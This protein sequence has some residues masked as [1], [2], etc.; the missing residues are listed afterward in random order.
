MDL[1]ATSSVRTDLAAGSGRRPAAGPWRRLWDRRPGRPPPRRAGRTRSPAASARAS[2]SDG[3]R[4]GLDDHDRQAARPRHG[5]VEPVA[6][7]EELDAAR[8]LRRARRWPSSRST[9]APPGPGTCRPC[10]PGAAAEPALERLLDLGDVGVVRRHDEDV[11][12]RQRRTRRPSRSVHG[13]PR[14]G[15]TSVGDASASSGSTATS[16]PWS[17]GEQRIPVPSTGPAPMALARVGGV[18]LEPALVEHLGDEPVDRGMHP[19]GRVAGTSRDPAAM[20]CARR[21]GGAPAPTRRRRR[22]GRPAR[23][24][25]AG[26]GRRAGRSSSRR[27]RIATTLA[28]ES[29]PAS[30]TK[31][32]SSSVH[33]RAGE[34]PAVPAATSTGPSARAGP[35]S[36]FVPARRHRAAVGRLVV[37][38]RWKT[39]SGDPG[40]ARGLVGLVEHV[41]DRLVRLGGHPDPPARRDQRDDL[42][43]PGPGLA[44]AGRALDRQDARSRSRSRAIRRG[45]ERGSPGRERLAGRHAGD[46]RR[47]AAGGGP[48]RLG[49]ARAVDPAVR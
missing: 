35:T 12:E 16:P 23:P 14:S 26:S 40:L 19:V 43:R 27:R 7:V 44:R 37:V 17:T 3:S 34:E 36:A 47:P 46:P 24:G 30:S 5:D 49:T 38:E 8:Q 29:W 48:G 28:S 13:P 18:G 2:G 10:R 20:R 22:D 21:R 4:S 33:L 41:R 42:R 32:T 11:V 31:R 39:R 45:I 9:P 15:S 6:R 25:A 1:L